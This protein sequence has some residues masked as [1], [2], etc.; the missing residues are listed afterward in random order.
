MKKNNMI[1][2][3]FQ[4]PNALSFFDPLLDPTSQMQMVALG[5]EDFPLVTEA[6]FTFGFPADLE[7]G[8]VMVSSFYTSLEEANQQ[9]T[10]QGVF[11]S[12]K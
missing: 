7:E 12:C 8:E 6:P 11:L 1:R 4:P 5:D 2:L 3:L 9:F 10:I